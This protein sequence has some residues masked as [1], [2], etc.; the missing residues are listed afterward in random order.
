MLQCAAIILFLLD[1]SGSI[2]GD[3]W[4]MMLRGHAEAIANE[5][6]ARV[7]ENDAPIAVAFY[8]FADRTY[9]I[10]DFR[11]L[12][13]RAEAESTANELASSRRPSESWTAVGQALQDA[14]QAISTRA[15]CQSDSLI[16]DV[17]SD[18]ESPDFSIAE[19]ARDRAQELTIKV[20]VLGIGRSAFEWLNNHVRTYDGF[21][22]Q[23]DTMDDI[24]P[25]LRRKVV[26][27]VSQ[28]D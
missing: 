22:M 8:G 9:P 17:V 23:A 4:R 11:V 15:P 12:R 1:S 13:S 7:I 18:G 28:R 14:V 2:S 21:Y 3:D 24:V 16:I 20:N 26:L 10:I 27:E 6:I 19:R 25:T 5:Q